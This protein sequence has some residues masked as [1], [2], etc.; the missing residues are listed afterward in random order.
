MCVQAAPAACPGCCVWEILELRMATQEEIAGSELA[1]AQ[2]GGIAGVSIEGMP[3]RVCNGAYLAAGQYEGCPRFAST[4]GKHLYYDRE[5]KRWCLNHAF[6]P[7]SHTS[8]AHITSASGRLPTGVQQWHVVQHWHKM[9][10]SALQQGDHTEDL[11]I[12]VALLRTP[13][14][15]DAYRTP[16][17]RQKREEDRSALEQTLTEEERQPYTLVLTDLAGNSLAIPSVRVSDTVEELKQR[18][19]SLNGMEPDEQ[20][21]VYGTAAQNTL[22]IETRTLL[23]YGVKRGSLLMLHVQP[24]EQSAARREQRAAT[25]AAAKATMHAAFAQRQSLLNWLYVSLL[26]GG[27]ALQQAGWW[28]LYS[29]VGL[30]CGIL[31][32]AMMLSG[33]FGFHFGIVHTHWWHE[34]IAWDRDI[35]DNMAVCGARHNHAV[36]CLIYLG[37]FILAGFATFSV[38]QCP[39]AG[40][41]QDPSTWRPLRADEQRHYTL[42]PDG[43]SVLSTIHDQGYTS[44]MFVWVS[45]ET[46]ADRWV[47]PDEVDKLE[48]TCMDDRGRSCMNATHGIAIKGLDEVWQTSSLGK[49]QLSTWGERRSCTDRGGCG[50]ST[51]FAV[52]SI[53]LLLFGEWLACRCCVV[54]NEFSRL[55]RG[56]RGPGDEAVIQ[57]I[58]E[59]H[60][61]VLRVAERATERQRA[62]DAA[63]D[64][65]TFAEEPRGDTPAEMAEV[66]LRQR[67]QSAAYA[68]LI[69]FGLGTIQ[70]GI[71]ALYSDVALLCGLG[72]GVLVTFATYH[73]VALEHS[74][75][76][77]VGTLLTAAE[78]RWE[79]ARTDP[80]TEELVH[81]TPL[82][83][84]E[85]KTRTQDKFQGVL[86]GLLICSILY[87]VASAILCPPTG[88]APAFVI[89]NST[90]V[91][92]DS[93]HPP[94]DCPGLE[95]FEELNGRPIRTRASLTEDQVEY[96]MQY[97]K[98]WVAT[99]RSSTWGERFSFKPFPHDSFAEG[100]DC[101]I[102]IFNPVGMIFMLGLL[103]VCLVTLKNEVCELWRGAAQ[104]AAPAGP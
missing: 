96:M 51:T 34:R 74:R 18:I 59:R 13:A 22:E 16:A 4:E 58:E 80:D 83:P 55:R 62:N 76:W 60:D 20:R 36:D 69:C 42:S 53:L 38:Q 86:F 3:E 56:E 65:E 87:V 7:A 15:L 95:L 41:V 23:S 99:N 24:A 11:P 91:T 10:R 94:P 47:R 77:T 30:T 90:N 37:Y 75:A 1:A 31:G 17:E 9:H 52:L 27:M 63:V 44:S 92:C 82:R 98:Y 29:D 28:S 54:I 14:D 46:S 25:A 32:G 84:G 73:F 67:W 35:N 66:F 2:L 26:Y 57:E 100:L 71:W 70:A 79:N 97:K 5:E 68:V 72:G 40:T 104:A 48:Y 102:T 85:R 43:Y 64:A 6:S 33:V 103:A 8:L 49:R 101:G 81:S 93:Y 39:A 50:R 45:C 19:K 12:E 88:V 78:L 89:P 61:H 21:L